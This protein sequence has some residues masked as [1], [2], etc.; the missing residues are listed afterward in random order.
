VV[1]IDAGELIGIPGQ[2][3][4]T[5]PFRAHSEYRYLTDR[6]RPGGLL[7]FDPQDGWRDF[8]ATATESDRVWTGDL[9][10]DCDGEPMPGFAGWLAARGRR[11]IASRHLMAVMIGSSPT[12]C[13]WP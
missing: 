8:V 1:L 7:A 2:G 13:V 12:V 6:N 10:G 4:V 5:Y 9:G 3:D 11:P